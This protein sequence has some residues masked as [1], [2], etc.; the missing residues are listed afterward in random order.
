MPITPKTP[1]T[2]DASIN[3]Q[4]LY[5]LPGADVD[6][7]V[8]GRSAFELVGTAAV[9]A[10]IR[11]HG[12]ALKLPERVLGGL[13]T[14]AFVLLDR[15]FET[16][17]AG[18]RDA[19]RAVARRFGRNF[20]WVLVGLRH[21]AAVTSPRPT[22]DEWIAAHWRTLERVWLGGGLIRGHLGDRLI[23][24]V[25]TVFAETGTPPFEMLRDRFGP[26]LP[27]VGAARCV[28]GGDRSASVLDFGGTGVKRG[29]AFYHGGA[30]ARLRTLP[31][32]PTDWDGDL[33]RPDDVRRFRDQFMIPAI[34]ATV[35]HTRPE[36]P[37]V[38]VSIAAYVDETGEP[39][40]R[41]GL[42]YP[43]VGELAGNLQQT[44]SDEVSRRIGREL[45]V[46]LIHDG[47]AAASA[48]P[49]DT[50]MALGTAIGIGYAPAVAAPRPLAAGF[51]VTAAEG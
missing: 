21:P 30:L 43:A 47:T 5:D 51:E 29:E 45:H 7:G 48:H 40:R 10:M 36:S 17:D 42:I 1:L 50:V 37:H 22:W 25:L 6:D 2:P 38:A 12:A 16:D 11:A 18:V 28:P 20:G 31:T 26:S 34:A 9:Y 41:E 4:T 15:C 14:E 3:R 8:R 44:L 23:E 49:G 35:E 32:L 13:N 24:D 46:R 33:Q 39:Y 19:A 27:M